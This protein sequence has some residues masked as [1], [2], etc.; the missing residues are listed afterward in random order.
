M[1]Q[2]D[3]EKSGGPEPGMQAWQIVLDWTMWSVTGIVGSLY[4]GLEAWQRAARVQGE[5]GDTL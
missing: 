3:E 2:S 5:T 4:I 1:N